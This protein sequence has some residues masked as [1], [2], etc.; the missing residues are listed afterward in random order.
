D[1]AEEAV[2]KADLVEALKRVE[3]KLSELKSASHSKDT[4]TN[5]EALAKRIEAFEGHK[6]KLQDKIAAVDE[7]LKNAD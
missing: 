6:S 2:G 4:N 7:Q 1:K 3:A 5:V